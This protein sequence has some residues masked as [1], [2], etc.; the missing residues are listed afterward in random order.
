MSESIG[1]RT[2]AHRR[3]RR[4]AALLVG[5]LIALIVAGAAL[6]Q[7]ANPFVIETAIEIEAPPEVVWD[8]LTD[9]EAYPEWNPSLVGMTGALEPGSTLRFATDATD[10][11][12]VFEPVV[13]EVRRYEHL[14]WEGTLL[15][16][17]LFDGEHSFTL[18]PTAAGHTLLTQAEF[19]RGVTV[20]FLT[21]WL[22]DNTKP[23]F[24]AMNEA[25]KTRSEDSAGH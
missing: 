5:L 25:L 18:E 14:R 19:F 20:P 17:G 9:F 7:R 11:A 10:E 1:G 3:A 8:V 16:T 15:I 12:L 2:H 21:R 24:I 22:T 13:R 6:W 4:R 23:D